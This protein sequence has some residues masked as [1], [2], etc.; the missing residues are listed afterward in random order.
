MRRIKNSN[1]EKRAWGLRT[2]WF[3][4]IALMLTP[5]FSFA[6][7][8]APPNPSIAKALY[9]LET[10]QPKKALA[11]LEDAIKGNPTDASLLYYLG[12]VQVKTGD[13]TKA[14]ASFDKG[15][16]LNDKEPLNY[17]GKGYISLLEKKS[18]DG[19]IQFDKALGMTR[20]KNITVLKAIAEAYLVDN[21]YS[22]DAIGLLNKAKSLSDADPGL[23]LLLGDTYVLQNTGG[24]VGPALTCYENALAI[25]L[26]DVTA[27]S[28]S[29]A[30]AHFK[31]GEVYQKTKNNEVAQESFIKSI[32]SDPNYTPAYKELGE[33][34]YLNKEAEKAVKTYEKY[35]SLTEKPE[36][37]QYQYQYA[38]FLFM[39]KDY[40]KAN[41]VFAKIADAKDVT[42]TTLRFYGVSLFEEGDKL[43][44]DKVEKEKSLQLSKKS[45]EV[46]EKYLAKEK[47]ENITANDYNYYGKTLLKLKQDS[48]GINA[49]QKSLALNQD[50]LDILRLTGDAYFKAKK[51]AQAVDIYKRVIKLQSPPYALDFFNIGRSY[52]YVNNLAAADSAFSK[53]IELAPDK[54]IGYVW[55]A[56]TKAVLE[57]TM[58]QEG[59]A[60]PYF[61]KVVELASPAPEKNKKDLISA[62]QYLSYYYYSQK[63]YPAAKSIYEKWLTLDPENKDA[64]SALDILKKGKG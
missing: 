48:L 42:L 19:K 21:K 34:Y 15:I 8:D 7:K 53:L 38:F 63:D 2:M 35:L 49:L 24:N 30:K 6:Q 26:T 40:K 20:S 52:Y 18:A 55:E 43:D 11:E 27:K 60:K 3:L 46:F 29:D 22:V 31:I 39:A 36:T 50:Q 51:Y 61:E 56:N 1:F 16:Q 32:A 23:Q 4:S 45:R 17:V 10:E 44:K 47:T 25:K 33:I 59:L 41:D 62:Y 57:E 5:L 64:K 37:P 28:H 14:S 58:K 12:Y 13:Q 9:L 54:T